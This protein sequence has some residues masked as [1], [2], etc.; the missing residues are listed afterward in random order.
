MAKVQ[1]LKCTCKNDYQDRVY[2]KGRRVMNYT[3]KSK[4]NDTAVYRCTVCKSELNGKV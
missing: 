4:S 2:G 3:T 1:V